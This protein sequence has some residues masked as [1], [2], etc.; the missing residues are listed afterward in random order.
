MWEAVCLAGIAAMDGGRRLMAARQL[1][2][3]QRPLAQSWQQQP[4][5]MMWPASGL[6]LKAAA[7]MVPAP[8]A[9]AAAG[10]E[11]GL[12]ALQTVTE[13]HKP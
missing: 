11:G 9:A 12:L 10:E 1:A 8:V 5:A 13:W 7:L 4:A 3:L 6:C 2:L